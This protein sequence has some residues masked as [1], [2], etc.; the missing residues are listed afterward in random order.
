MKTVR[1]W[2]RQEMIK[3]QTLQNKLQF[4]AMDPGEKVSLP[5]LRDTVSQINHT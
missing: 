5:N 1:R 2:L 4:Y 3:K